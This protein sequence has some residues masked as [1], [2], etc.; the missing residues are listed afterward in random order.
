MELLYH[1]GNNY[2]DALNPIIFN[3]FLGN[4]FFDSDNDIKLIGIG[5]ILGL[6]QG[7][8][9]KIIFSSGYADGDNSTYGNLPTIDE[10]YN[11]VCVRGPKTAEILN[12]DNSKSVAD[13]AILLP[14]VWELAGVKKKYKYSLILHHKSYDYYS[15]WKEICNDLDVHLIDVREDPKLITQQIVQSEYVLAEAMHGAIIAD[16][17]RVPWLP[18]KLYPG[19]NEFKWK[20]YSESIGLNIIF[21]ES[22][23]YLHSIDFYNKLIRNRIRVP[24]FISISISKFIHFYRIRKIKLFLRKVINDNNFYLSDNEILNQKQ[25]RLIELLE[26]LKKNHK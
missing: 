26:Q 15:N 4:D 9:S 14:K 20:D 24:G 19:V 2:G 18:L 1:K 7:D 21:K 5:S 10:S 6:K 22:K 17:Y 23:D 16:S 12:L 8:Y 13:G 25:L 11:V 3:Y